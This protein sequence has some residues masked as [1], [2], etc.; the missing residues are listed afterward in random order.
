MPASF[1]QVRFAARDGGTAMPGPTACA[2]LKAVMLEGDPD[3]L[4]KTLAVCLLSSAV[5]LAGPAGAQLV[6][7]ERVA[8][9]FA[10]PPALVAPP[11]EAR[12]IFVAEQPTG[13][14]LILDPVAICI[15]GR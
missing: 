8:T 4:G 11:C 10:H 2:T 1:S 13:A 9:G 5:G 6:R 14:I 7:A 3:P 15:L 12:R